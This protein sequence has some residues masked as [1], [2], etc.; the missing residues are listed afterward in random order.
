MM[1]TLSEDGETAQSSAYCLPMRAQKSINSKT[2]GGDAA[3]R[4]H[5][6]AS[7]WFLCSKM[8]HVVRLEGPTFDDKIER[9]YFV[10]V[11]VSQDL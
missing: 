5:Y 9:I 7:V 10:L 2:S 4:M 6:T 1:R 3:R 11:A 8:V